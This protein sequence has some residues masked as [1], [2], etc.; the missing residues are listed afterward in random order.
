M[1]TLALAILA[2]TLLSSCQ[3]ASD[4]PSTGTARGRYVGVGHYSPGSLWPQVARAAPAP[5]PAKARPEDDDQVIIV[6]DSLTGEL[7]Q[8]GNFSGRC[9]GQNPWSKPLE[10]NEAAPATLLRRPQEPAP[11]PAAQR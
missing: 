2:G 8:C 7:R 3:K 9:I 10:S 4:T 6:M 1:R 11:P 5:D